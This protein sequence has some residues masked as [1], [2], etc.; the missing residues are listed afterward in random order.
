V[1]LETGTYI[2]SL[3]STN[4]VATTDQLGG[5]ADHVHLL[6]STI[7]ATLPNVTGAVTPTHTEL[8][9][10]DG[11]TSA[12]QTQI[13]LKAPL[14]SPTFTG[15]PLVPT[16]ASGTNTSQAASTAFVIAESLSA[17][18][19]AQTGNNG[20]FITTD[21]TNASWAALPV[22]S[23]I[24]GISGTTAQFN[25]ELSDGDFQ[26]L[27]GTETVTN[28]RNEP[29]V[30]SAASY[31][32]DTGTSLSVATADIFIVTAQAGPLKL[33]NPGG[34]PTQGFPLV[35]RIKDN[36]VARALT[37]DTQFR[38]MGNA[39]PTT[40]VI[41]KTLYLGFVYNATDTKFDLVGVAQ[42]S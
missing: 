11:V 20:K 29:R 34:T 13:D 10:V 26:T 7:L 31:T 1:A 28:K 23:T 15:V 35:V 25:T 3:V 17:T 4:P 42:Q 22:I 41:N 5:V 18:L 12:I 37:Y 30:V 40:T 8:N 9:Y 33:N 27:A 14:A 36:G 24:V 19:P 21:G 38:A 32:T 2:N 39:L 16:A 6:K